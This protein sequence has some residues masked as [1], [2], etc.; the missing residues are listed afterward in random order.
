MV[1]LIGAGPGDAGLLT[2]KGRELLE[3]AD[4]VVFDRLVG[5][6]ILDM[7]PSSAKQIDVGKTAGSHPIP[8]HE[9]NRILIGEARHYTHVV[10]LKGGDPFLFGR[11]GEEALAL[12]EAGV[13]FQVVP[14]VTSAIATAAYAGIPVTHR[15]FAASLHIITGH[16]RDGEAIIDYDALVRLGGTW[17]FMM[18]VAT[19]A[20]I[21]DGLLDAGV[22][23]DTPAA[24][25]E[26]GTLP[27]QRKLLC[28]L[29]DLAETAAKA[30]SPAVIIVGQVC[31]LSE[32]LDWFGQLPLKGKRIMV[33]RPVVVQSQLCDALRSLGADVI[34][35]PAVETHLLPFA[36]EFGRYNW[37]I[38]TSGAGV[39]HF[40]DRLHTLGLDARALGGR[41]I[42]VVGPGTAAALKQHGITADFVPTVYAGDCLAEE[43][44]GSGLLG[45]TDCVGIFRAKQGSA[46][47]VEQL[48]KYC[49]VDDIAVYDTVKIAGEPIDTTDVDAVAFT[50]AGCVEAFAERCDTAGLTAFCIGKRTETAAIKAGMQVHTAKE[51]TI[52]SLADTIVA[53][54]R[55]NSI[56]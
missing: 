16:V 13:D 55:R 6:D 37:V 43:L 19:A 12:A 36:V 25:V 14:G 26:N 20:N 54:I 23:R 38:F 21:A 50:S 30:V 46:S 49:Q 42:A 9:I 31:S 29:A 2:I 27:H 10:R 32:K 56:C 5:A 45:R 34:A 51:A 33:T 24:I 53:V 3:S 4:V 11:G 22:P 40:F 39:N 18:A 44:I 7:I 1:Y 41:R 48:C 15:D 17:V 47:I 52:P 35:V 8:Q 28:R